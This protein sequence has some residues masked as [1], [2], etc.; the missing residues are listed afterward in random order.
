MEL[1][2]T[3]LLSAAA[4]MALS[5]GGAAFAQPTQQQAQAQTGLEEIVVTAQ[6]RSENVQNIPVSVSAFTVNELQ[7]RNITTTKD[8][9]MFV[10]NL[11]GNSNTGLGTA[12][13]YF[14]RGLGNTESVATFDPPVGTYVDDI[15][16]AR[17]N[18]NN[19]SFFDLEGIEVLRGPQG[20]LFGR[21]TSGG[22]INVKLRKP[23]D[24]ARGFGEISYGR[25]DAIMARASVDAPI[26]DNFSTQFAGF[27]SHTDGYVK[28]INTGQE[29][30]GSKSYGL[31]A[32]LRAKPSDTVTWD[33]SANHMYDNQLNALNFECQMFKSGVASPGAPANCKGRF[34]ITGYKKNPGG[35]SLSN[36]L[37]G[38]PGPG[39]APNTFVANAQ[40]V[41]YTIANGKANQ[42]LGNKTSQSIFA[43][44]IEIAA[45]DVTVNFIT[46][47][48]KLD[49]KYNFDFQDGRAGRSLALP[50]PV[51]LFI[52][53]AAGVV[54]PNGGPLVLDNKSKADE[55]TQEVKATGNL[56]DSVKY[57][58]GVYYFHDKN[59]TDYV[60]I[61]TGFL[62]PVAPQTAASFRPY[63]TTVSG[64]RL[65]NNNTTSVAA[66]VQ[67]DVDITEQFSATAGIRYTDERKT[68]RIKDQRD[69]RVNPI[70][71]GV[72][73]PDFRLETANLARA[74]FP[75]KLVTKL[76]TPHFALN[77]QAND[78][79]L[80]FVTA[81]RGFRSGGWN[82]RGLDI[83]TFAPFFA[84][85]VWAYEAGMKS[86]WADDRFRA[87]VTLFDNEV[88][89]FQ[90]PSSFVP[91][92]GIATFITGN[93][94]DFRSKGVEGEFQALPMDGLT[95]F[96]TVGH[97][98]TK[99]TN[100]PAS[101]VTQQANCKALRATGNPGAGVCATAIVTY[102]GNIAKPA[103]TPEWTLA[104]GASYDIET[105]MG[106]KV[107]PSVNVSHESSY[108]TA[109]ANLSYY[110]NAA[111][112]VNVTGDG[113]FVSGSHTSGFT[114]VNASLAIESDDEAWRAVVDCSNC[115][116]RVWSQ[117]SVSGY[118]F[119]TP[120][121]VWSVRIKRSF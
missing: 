12:N 53:A 30:N 28:A 93:A 6:R 86:Q 83:T 26:N 60:D 23:G 80:L 50:N 82:V 100:I 87:N 95:L 110:I 4:T 111:G 38:I 14:M 19:F 61:N 97:Q 45:E 65:L 75:D 32:A 17:Q 119:I 5:V 66:Y 25:F 10:P 20:T 27:Y 42:E 73:R 36:V 35:S 76:W 64:D 79:V 8:L 74:G 84:E 13:V 114:V 71:A 116:N 33:L 107:S 22:A 96:T 121:G 3:A 40:F 39:A 88:S 34:A 56:S 68:L 7:R 55:F 70:V 16:I 21:N 2:K 113:K 37:I 51:P 46:G 62:P 9:I 52:A 85:K 57:V 59:E 58:A 18:M 115:F 104:A 67:A 101:S 112:V 117:S 94:A 77:F 106:V 31:R 105:S 91:I 108:E 11:Q 54:S 49:Q 102:D 15:Y 48:L 89:G 78:D 41:P 92:T 120:P 109:G 24:E 98:K 63:R 43:S 69:P 44:N 90:L 1:S 47:Y 81:T 29:L 99:Y 103:R 72:Q 118:S